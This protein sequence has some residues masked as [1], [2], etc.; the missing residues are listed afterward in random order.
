MDLGKIQVLLFDI[1]SNDKLVISVFL[2]LN[3]RK[4]QLNNH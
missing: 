1:F 4:S 2:T 3:F